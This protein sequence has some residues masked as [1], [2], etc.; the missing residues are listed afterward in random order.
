MKA[1]RVA[2][3]AMIVAVVPIVW[4][5]VAQAAASHRHHRADADGLRVSA[6]GGGSLTPLASVPDAGLI[7][8]AT[9]GGPLTPLA[10]PK[11][12]VG[13]TTATV[14]SADTDGRPG[15]GLVA[16]LALAGGALALAAMR[17]RRR[18]RVVVA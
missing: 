3:L 1:S 11:H 16:A 9:G 18:A 7:V 12:R 4:S 5:P 15:P 17:R 8:S 13:A 6:V 10:P 2:L 14:A